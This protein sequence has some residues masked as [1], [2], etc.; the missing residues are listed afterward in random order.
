MAR[1]ASRIW[2]QWQDLLLMLPAGA[3]GRDFSTG[4]DAGDRG[5]ETPIAPSGRDAPGHTAG[6]DPGDRAW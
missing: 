4:E 1:R 6:K 2:R 3:S 5:A